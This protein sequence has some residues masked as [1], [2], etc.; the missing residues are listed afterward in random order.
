MASRFMTASVDDSATGVLTIAEA[1][2]ERDGPRL[3][4]HSHAKRRPKAALAIVGLPCAL[5]PGGDDQSARFFSSSSCSRKC[6]SSSLPASRA[7][8]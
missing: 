6:A 2:S 4:R 3:H 5:T 8:S 1:S 7:A